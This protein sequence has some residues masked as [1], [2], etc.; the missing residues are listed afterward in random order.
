[1]THL[2]MTKRIETP[3]FRAE[4]ARL[5]WHRGR[6]YWIRECAELVNGKWEGFIS[7]RPVGG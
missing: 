5:T 4:P 6:R 2:N 1:M 7:M 3:D